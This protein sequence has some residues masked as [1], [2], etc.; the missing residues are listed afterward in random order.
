MRQQIAAG[1]LS[2]EKAGRDRLV[3]ANAFCFL[4]VLGRRTFRPLAAPRP[5]AENYAAH[6][7]ACP[8]DRGVPRV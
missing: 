1:R 5:D 4:R 2:A 3:A 8:E 7:P 6:P